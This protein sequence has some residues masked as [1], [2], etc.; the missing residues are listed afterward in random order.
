MHVHDQILLYIK[1]SGPTTPTRIAK[2]IKEET[3]IASAHLSDLSS[4]RKLRI[5]DLKVGGSPLYYLPGQEDQLYRFAAGNMNEK[6]VMVLE[7]LKEERVLREGDLDLL[8]K[9][10]LRRLKDFAIPLQVSTPDRTE[11]F[12]KWHLLSAD[13]TNEGIKNILK[14]EMEEKK[15]EI[16]ETPAEEPVTPAEPEVVPEKVKEKP[17]KE[18][19]EKAVEEA[20]VEEKVVDDPK[21][22]PK[23]E[24]KKEKVIEE[25]TKKEVKKEQPKAEKKKE[26]ADEQHTLEEKP[27]PTIKKKVVND[28]FLPIIEAYCKELDITMRDMEMIRKN[29]EI[30]F[31][32]DIPSVIGRTRYFCKAKKKNRCDEKDLSAAF[33]EAQMKK[34]PLLF[35]YS[36]DLNKKAQE[37][38]ESDALQNV[39]VKKIENES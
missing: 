22:E 36:N 34:L 38:L 3:L 33:V 15:E 24:S 14:P 28:P 1:A 7:R 12:W 6:D 29:S 18:K 16:Q 27:V 23:K 21:K 19:K 9:V 39:V 10:A 5:S 35:L 26:G 25:E 4:Q 32:G 8:S 30:N 37:M 11:L 31:I 2:V 17:K 20:V 13:Q